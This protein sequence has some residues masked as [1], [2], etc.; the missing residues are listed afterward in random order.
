MK[1]TKAY[2][3]QEALGSFQG[4]N[5]SVPST[6]LDP[7][8]SP[9]CVNV[10][11]ENGEIKKRSGYLQLGDT[12]ATGD[13]VVGTMSFTSLTGTTKQIA[14]TTKNQFMFDPSTETWDIMGEIL[15]ACE[16]DWTGEASASVEFD[17]TTFK[18]G[19]KSLKVTIDNA[20]TT[21][22]TAYTADFT[23]I[24]AE[25]ARLGTLS[26]WVMS[27]EDLTAGDFSLII[28]EA[29]GGAKSATYEE[30]LIPA[31]LKDVW[32]LIRVSGD[33]TSLNAVKSVGLYQNVDK[34]LI[35]WC[36]DIRI[37]MQ[38]TG[39]EDDYLDWTV[40]VDNSG[41]FLFITN[42]KDFP[43]YW[44]GAWN[45]FKAAPINFPNFVCCKT[46]RVYMGRMI[47]GN[48]KLSDREPFTLLYC[49]IADFTDWI[50]SGVTGGIIIPDSCGE[51]IK[52]LLLGDQL[53]VR[54]ENSTG[55]INFIGGDL[56]FTY[57]QLSQESSLL[58]GKALSQVGPYH[59][60]IG[61]TNFWMF[62]GT[63]IE[64]PI[65]NMIKDT[66]QSDVSVEYKNRAATF[67]D[68]LKQH[69]YCLVPTSDT[70]SIIYLVEYDIL[71]IQNFKWT[72][73][74][75]TDRPTCFGLY[76]RDTS[77]N[78][79]TGSIVTLPWEEFTGSWNT[80]AAKKGSLLRL[81]GTSNGKLLV[82]EDIAASDAGS[83]ISAKWETPD[84]VIPQVYRSM[85]AR[86]TEFELELFGNEVDVSY[87][88]DGGKDWIL[89]NTLALTTEWNRY[90]VFLDVVSNTIRFK[91]SHNLSN[92]T[93]KLRWFRLWFRGASI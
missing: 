16:T 48:I 50:T 41:K 13:P 27:S 4:L 69:M 38:W 62:D 21:G 26:M 67:H 57:S 85:L 49:N 54:S 45:T 33:Y 63:R 17:T 72:R 36:D 11:V 25:S 22:L 59:L 81:M 70:E 47:L 32:T 7:K 34:P 31:I 8:F 87:S 71:N 10:F 53:I 74:I 30:Y 44:D 66:F 12:L 88:I 76:Q 15:S 78:W 18:R 28:T 92:G 14:I 73:H 9:D 5:T 40:G 93:F 23:P 83:V 29:S 60:S 55:T 90:K 35:I 75:Y 43:L 37:S 1:P 56:G 51:I 3:P 68:S 2:L 77:L 82:A 64:T 65:G 84:F 42:G 24:D 58:C 46:M 89:L 86:W 39:T 52:L 20:F 61:D 80:T 19:V 91:I 79:N 6:M